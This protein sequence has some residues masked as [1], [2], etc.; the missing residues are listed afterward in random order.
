MLKKKTFENF[1]IFRMARA[2]LVGRIFKF[3]NSKISSSGNVDPLFVE[4]TK[5]TATE[6]REVMR[7]PNTILPKPLVSLQEGGV[8]DSR[9]LFPYTREELFKIYHER[10]DETRCRSCASWGTGWGRPPCIRTSPD[11]IREYSLD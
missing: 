10:Q 6:T 4:Q 9:V 11:P 3:P 7:A 1:V 5:W 2:T 8:H